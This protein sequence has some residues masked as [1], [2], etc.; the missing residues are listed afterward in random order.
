MFVAWPLDFFAWSCE[1]FSAK[2]AAAAPRAPCYHE[3]AEREVMMRWCT[4]QEPYR[5]CISKKNIAEIIQKYH[6]QSGF[7]YDYSDYTGFQPGFFFL[8]VWRP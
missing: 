1:R 6:H 8:V 3:D 5:D 7:C 2:I 4:S